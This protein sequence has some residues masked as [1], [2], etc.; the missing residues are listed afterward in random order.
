[1]K[2]LIIKDLYMLKHNFKF[3]GIIILVLACTSAFSGGSVFLTIYP[4]FLAAMMAQN[5]IAF[6]E[7]YRWDRYCGALPCSRKEYVA[8]KYLMGLICAATALL[9]N[10]AALLVRYFCFGMEL[11]ELSF[12]LSTM[13]IAAFLAPSI[14]YP[15]VFKYGSNKGRIAFIAFIGI[16]TGISV[17]LEGISVQP[18][19]F[20]VSIAPWLACLLCPCMYAASFFISARIYKKKEL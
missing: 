14:S 4:V 12:L 13:F 7:S 17:T 3:Y 1:M 11:W 16:I 8:C 18:P 6:D 20:L 5:L 10:A 19:Q 2:G 9:L 15:L